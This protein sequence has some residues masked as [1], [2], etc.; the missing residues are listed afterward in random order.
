MI[1]PSPLFYLTPEHGHSKGDVWYAYYKGRNTMRK[2]VV[3]AF[4]GGMFLSGVIFEVL[5]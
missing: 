5:R 4:V 1:S 2:W 3:L